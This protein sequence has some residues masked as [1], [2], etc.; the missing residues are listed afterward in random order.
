MFLERRSNIR[1]LR[2][3]AKKKMMN[4]RKRLNSHLDIIHANNHKEPDW[5][6]DFYFAPVYA[7]GRILSSSMLESILFQAY[8]NQ[9]I[10]DIFN[11][12]CGVRYRVSYVL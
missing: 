12:F 7:G 9:F 2:P 11:A 5:S 6:D 3:T 4:K 10:L 8:H 1:F